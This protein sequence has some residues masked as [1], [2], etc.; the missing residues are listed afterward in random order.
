MRMRCLNR[1]SKDWSNYGGRGITICQAWLD[2]FEAFFADVGAKP[3][4]KHSIDRI[5]SDGNYEPS[6]CRWATIIQQA[7]NRRGNRRITFGGETLLLSEWAK[8]LG[9]CNA[10]L[11]ERL[12]KWPV[13]KALGTAAI[14]VRERTETGAYAEAAS[15]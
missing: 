1:N 13:E 8:R 11:F 12:A 4:P 9:I 14:R 6:N 10:S 2:S 5:N 15:D 3:S 7:G